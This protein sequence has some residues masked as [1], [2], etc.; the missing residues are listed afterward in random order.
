MAFHGAS[1]MAVAQR[2][3][4]PADLPRVAYSIREAA[5]MLG[6]TAAALRR[7]CERNARRDGARLVADLALGIRAHKHGVAG[8]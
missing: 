4:H 2:S 7:D 5:T 1:S 3:R 6:K 8:T